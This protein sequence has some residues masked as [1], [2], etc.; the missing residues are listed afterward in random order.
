[1][2][3]LSTLTEICCSVPTTPTTGLPHSETEGRKSGSICNRIQLRKNITSTQ[4]SSVPSRK[5]RAFRP[6]LLHNQNH[7]PLLLYTLWWKWRQLC[8]NNPQ[9][10]RYKRTAG[11]KV[12]WEK[13]RQIFQRVKANRRAFQPPKALLSL[14]PSHP[15][16]S[17]SDYVNIVNP[18]L[19]SH[20]LFDF[21]HL[22]LPN[23]SWWMKFGPVNCV[24]GRI[25]VSDM[26]I[27]CVGGWVRSVVRS[28]A[29]FVAWQVMTAILNC[30]KTHHFFVCSAFTISSSPT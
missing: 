17:T 15:L 14:S 29:W 9:M 18:S 10:I 25:R 24:R 28:V 21:L 23:S 13:R 12:K 5:L 8:V 16:S 6:I 22:I 20:S 3:T 1:M 27:N 30:I 19:W 11:E 7:P 26:F 4:Q 2:E